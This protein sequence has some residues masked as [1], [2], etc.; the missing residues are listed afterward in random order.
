MLTLLKIMVTYVDLSCRVSFKF[1]AHMW[2]VTLKISMFFFTVRIVSVPWLLT[3]PD[4]RGV[5]PIPQR[6]F[7]DNFC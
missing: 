5:E 2:I 7:L 3:L 4:L 1:L 6:F